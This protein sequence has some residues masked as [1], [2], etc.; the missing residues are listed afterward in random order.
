MKKYYIFGIVVLFFVI[1]LL[2]LRS[3]NGGEDN[4][5]KDSKGIYVKH[6]NPFNI[7]DYVEDQQ[8]AIICSNS[9]YDKEK[10]KSAEFNSQCL[11]TCL[12]YSVDIVHIPRT[13][14]DNKIENQCADYRNGIT[15]SFIELDRNGEIVRVV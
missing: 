9:L 7:P 14:E 12:D 3:F 8:K 5:I 6:G 10:N 11:G 4:W 2:F 13:S 15:K 1:L